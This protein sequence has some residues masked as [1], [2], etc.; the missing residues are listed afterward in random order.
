ML[1][2]T[3]TNYAKK[4]VCYT[5]C[6]ML[7]FMVL[8]TSVLLSACSDNNV[9]NTD[10]SKIKSV[11]G[12]GFMDVDGPKLNAVAVEYDCEISAD[13]VSAD[14]FSLSVYN[15]MMLAD[16]D[17]TQIGNI[18]NIYVNNS[19][20]TSTVGG[21]QTGKY[22]IMEL[23]TDY[24]A[25]EELTYTNSLAVKVTQT[26]DIIAVDGTVLSASV[27]SVR[28]TYS[29]GKLIVNIPEVEGFKYYT[30]LQT[31]YQKDGDAYTVKNC[32]DQRDGHYEDVDLSYALYLPENYNPNG[33]Y[34]LMTLQ[35]PAAEAN[36]H[37]FEAVITYRSAAIYASEEMQQ[38][39]KDEHGLDGLVVVVPVVTQRVNDNGGT[40]AQYQAIVSLWDYI[41]DEYNID[42]DH[43]YG[44]GQSVGGMILL[45]TNRNRDNF[46]AGILLYNNQ[47]GQ[48][49]YVDTVFERSMSFTKT[50]AESAT[51]HYPRVDTDIT[52]DYSL[53]TEGNK[54]YD[55]HDPYNYYYLVSDD[56]VLV[57]NYKT[58]GIS[59]DSWNEMKYL[60]DDLTGTSFDILSVDTK[61]SLTDQESDI[62]AYLNTKGSLNINVVSFDSGTCFRKY[63]TS[64]K[65]VL[66]QSRTTEISREKLDLNKPFEI[67]DEQ[68]QTEER[69][70][71]F[72]TA[73]GSTLH[74]VGV[75]DGVADK[76]D[77]YFLTGKR[78]AGTQGYNSGWYTLGSAADAV[79][80]WLPD[81]MSWQKGV[82][83]G[84]IEEVTVI[85]DSAIAIKYNCD[86][87][88]LNVRLKGEE[89]Y[90][91]CS[92]TYRDNETIVIDPYAFYDADK[93]LI[94]LTISNIYVNSSAAIVSGAATRSGS[95]NYVIV[96]LSGGN[97]SSVAA[98]LQLTTINT[99]SVFCNASYKYYMVG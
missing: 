32:F 89:V 72:K 82:S 76:S 67:A 40:P 81:G 19:A 42:P 57:L 46:F 8:L 43:V 21:T 39:V 4:A 11:V 44:S 59:V 55:G 7:A 15:N 56:N 17:K 75:A 78:G 94:N 38:V 31:H 96:E 85:S 20:A 22:V 98:L 83:I 2:Y 71:S 65:W 66:S 58:N 13:A 97:A 64:Y 45:E 84:H 3:K 33:K 54:V 10:E 14:T 60:Y 61:K 52:W 99:D 62:S 34:A 26:K 25:V 41:I 92:G 73:V 86:L 93:E 12:I 9:P 29:D 35:N 50:V 87:S 48:N 47:W 6:I 74:T 1:R 27:T 36:T 95:G 28:N 51:F 91:I 5:L 18:T 79:P 77:I 69:K 23:Y 37:P 30:N 68:I 88:G 80:G 90:N 16:G 24:A 49:Y 53:D 70:L 63:D